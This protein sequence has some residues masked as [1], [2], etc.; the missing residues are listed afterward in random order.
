M[1][2]KLLLQN[3]IKNFLGI[4]PKPMGKNLIYDIFEYLNKGETKKKQ[5]QNR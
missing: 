2:P 4:Y 5:N 3:L 1:H